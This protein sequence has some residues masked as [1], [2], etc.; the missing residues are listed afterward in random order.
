MQQQRFQSIHLVVWTVLVLSTNANNVCDCQQASFTE[1][2]LSLGSSSSL[3]VA[4][5]LC[6]S[7]ST[8]DTA[9]S[10]SSLSHP[11][12]SLR[13]RYCETLSISRVYSNDAMNNNNDDCRVNPFCDNAHQA[14]CVIDGKCNALLRQPNQLRCTDYVTLPLLDPLSSIQWFGMNDTYTGVPDPSCGHDSRDNNPVCV[15]P[16]VTELQSIQV[17]A[18]QQQQEEEEEKTQ[19]CFSYNASL[20]N[21]CDG[22]CLDVTL[23]ANQPKRLDVAKSGLYNAWV[24]FTVQELDPTTAGASPTNGNVC[25]CQ[26]P[27]SMLSLLTSAEETGTALVATDRC[28]DAASDGVVIAALD[29]DDAS[30]QSNDNSAATTM[31]YRYCFTPMERRVYHDLDCA[32]HSEWCVNAK[33]ESCTIHKYCHEQV[34][35]PQPECTEYTSQT[36]QDNDDDDDNLELFVLL[37][38]GSTTTT[39]AKSIS[40]RNDDLK[41]GTYTDSQGMAKPLCGSV[42]TVHVEAHSLR[43]FTTASH[44]C[45]AYDVSNTPSPCSGRCFVMDSDRTHTFAVM[46]AQD[47]GAVHGRVWLEFTTTNKEQPPPPLTPRRRGLSRTRIVLIVGCILGTLAVASVVVVQYNNRRWHQVH[48][49]IEDQNKDMNV[50]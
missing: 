8:V 47:D 18:R 34:E 42:P 1:T 46:G 19:V 6:P 14:S 43:M 38:S 23:I 27:V 15:H 28:A 12:L 45:F 35:Q 33:E 17:T 3:D 2:L 7:R 31:R 20:A 41:C 13:Y 5:P 49:E 24:E 4:K 30:G 50:V 9:S 48:E 39:A 40:S 10:S 36:I 11:P 16:L 44:V 26:S 29:T 21:P 22:S 25:E 37:D 32:N